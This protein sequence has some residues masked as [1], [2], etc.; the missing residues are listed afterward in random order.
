MQLF[1]N[2]RL[3]ALVDMDVPHDL[4][5]GLVNLRQR[6]QGRA[7]LRLRLHRQPHIAAERVRVFAR[8]PPSTVHQLGC[9]GIQHNSLAQKHVGHRRQIT[10]GD[11]FGHRPHGIAHLCRVTFDGVAGDNLASKV[12]GEKPVPDEGLKPQFGQCFAFWLARRH[13]NVSGFFRLRHA[14]GAL[15]FNRLI[16]V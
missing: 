12:I 15:P 9:V 7:A 16:R 14:L 11:A 10:R 3:P 8:V 6:F 1:G 13:C 4:F 2:H 5:A